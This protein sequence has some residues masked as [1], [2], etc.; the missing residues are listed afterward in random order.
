[1]P[2]NINFNNEESV[3]VF[4]DCIFAYGG[5][6]LFFMVFVCAVF[7]PDRFEKFIALVYKILSKIFKTVPVI[8]KKYI[9]HDFQSRANSF[10]N[11]FLKKEI[12]GFIPIK[13]KVEWVSDNEIPKSFLENG[14]MIVRMR[15]DDNENKNFVNA[16][17]I[18]IAENLLIKAKRYISKKQKES[19]DLFVGKKIF[20][21]EKEDVVKE[22]IEDFLH[23][24]IEEKVVDNLFVKYQSIDN[25][26]L[27]F[28]V[29]IQEM[30][31]LGEKVF[32]NRKDNL[33][34]T[35]VTNLIE[36]LNNYSKRKIRE[37]IDN[38]FSGNYCKFGMIIIGK[39]DK[40]Y[41]QGSTPYKRYIEEFAKLN[42]ETLYLI[43][44][45]KNKDFIKDFVCGSTFL[46][47]INFVIFNEKEY[48][49]EICDAQ[50]CWKVK[51]YLLVIRN[52]AIKHYH[53]D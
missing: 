6:L 7:Y 31:F 3:K 38:K 41:E 50:E 30:T 19:I 44:D 14:K 8:R 40:I 51:N 26:G 48:V 49:G 18:F 45:I 13:L 27:F 39:T 1:M 35:E 21:K 32:N 42:L 29:F 34:I 15:K 4:F 52:N 23:P 5:W 17:M 25:K 20:E 11:G 47:E 53:I 33:I 43:G 28:S 12:K 10:V 46:K 36:F 37:E 22:F 2:I 9:Q 16:S 24:K